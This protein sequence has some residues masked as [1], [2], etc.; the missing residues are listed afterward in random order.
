MGLLL[1]PILGYEGGLL[2]LDSLACRETEGETRLRA[3]HKQKRF[4]R[5]YPLDSIR[6]DFLITGR[7]TLSV[8]NLHGTGKFR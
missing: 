7:A 6:V 3:I 5:H 2:R 8:V 1:Y 4:Y